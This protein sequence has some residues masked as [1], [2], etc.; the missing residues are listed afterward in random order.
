MHEEDDLP[1]LPRTVRVWLLRLLFLALGAAGVFWL[2]LHFADKHDFNA[3]T[4]EVQE[5]KDE[6]DA[7]NDTLDTMNDSL[8]VLDQS[9][10]EVPEAI[11]TPRARV[12]TKT[13]TKYRY[14]KSRGVLERMFTPRR[15]RVK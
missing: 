1:Q 8:Q 3:L 9:I 2:R 11:P 5:N 10:R 4:A 6:L 14:I 12:V 13:R 15:R 7:M